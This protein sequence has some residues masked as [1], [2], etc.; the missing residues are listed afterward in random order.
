MMERRDDALEW[1]TRPEGYVWFTP[2]ISKGLQEAGYTSSFTD[3]LCLQSG[4][5]YL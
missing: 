2:A 5:K 3:G 4:V 1:G